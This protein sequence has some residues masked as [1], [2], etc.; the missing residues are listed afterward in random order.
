MGT[1]DTPAQL[2]EERLHDFGEFA[3]LDDIHDLLDLIEEH[4]LLG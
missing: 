3:G 1:V 2:Y 4:D